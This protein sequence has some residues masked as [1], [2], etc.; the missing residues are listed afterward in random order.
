MA[1]LP[2]GSCSPE[3]NAPR[4]ED[5]RTDLEK[6]EANSRHAY[7]MLIQDLGAQI[8]AATA[9]RESKAQEKASKLHKAMVVQSK[10][11]YRQR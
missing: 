5:E 11:S 1:A 7:E 2:L 10:S 8:D 6:E 4:F 9:D 3:G